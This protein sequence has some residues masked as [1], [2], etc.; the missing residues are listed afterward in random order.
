M[1]IGCP[2]ENDGLYVTTTVQDK[3]V[4]VLIDTGANITILSEDFVHRL[5][6]EQKPCIKEI[7][8]YFMTATR[9]VSPFLGK[10]MMNIQIGEQRFE[11]EI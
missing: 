7:D 9:E 2:E 8:K 6:P 10:A 5:K 4:E 11:H 1:E 3:K